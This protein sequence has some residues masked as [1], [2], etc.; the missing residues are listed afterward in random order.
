MNLEEKKGFGEKGSKSQLMSEQLVSTEL[1][2]LIDA[3]YEKIR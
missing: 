2:G 3:K 1:H